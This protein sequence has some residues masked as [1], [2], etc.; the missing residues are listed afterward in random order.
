MG[1]DGG[2]Y[3]VLVPVDSTFIFAYLRNLYRE[4]MPQKLSELLQV[5]FMFNGE[6]WVCSRLERRGRKN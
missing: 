4:E 3:S 2:E 6:A 5:A 1:W